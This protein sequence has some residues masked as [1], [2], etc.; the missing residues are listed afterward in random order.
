MAM[1]ITDSP[2]LP[3]MLPLMLPPMLMLTPMRARAGALFFSFFDPVSSSFP[4]LITFCFFVFSF[5]FICSFVSLS[6]L[7]L[8]VVFSFSFRSIPQ[9]FPSF[10]FPFPLS[11]FYCYSFLFLISV[12]FSYSSYSLFTHRT[13]HGQTGPCTCSPTASTLAAPSVPSAQATTM[14][15][16]LSAPRCADLP[17]PHH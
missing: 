15:A 17:H 16:S 2:P 7:S 1:A 6:S 12:H 4:F 11:F 8:F 14:L 3:L 9:S 5:S 10:L 13:M